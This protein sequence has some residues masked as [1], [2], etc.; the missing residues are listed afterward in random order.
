MKKFSKNPENC[1]KKIRNLGTLEFINSVRLI[2][3]HPTGFFRITLRVFVGFERLVVRWNGKE[4]ALHV[5]LDLVKNIKSAK[6]VAE[7]LLQRVF[8]NSI[9]ENYVCEK[10]KNVI[11]ENLKILE[12]F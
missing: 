5:L 12:T 10:W 8:H 11:F 7:T 9:F 1:S 6:V 2:K 4:Q 3:A